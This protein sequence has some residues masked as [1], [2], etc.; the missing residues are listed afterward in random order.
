MHNPINIY[1][2]TDKRFVMIQG[3]VRAVTD[4]H[5]YNSVS[6]LADSDERGPSAPLISVMCFDNKY[7]I[8]FKALT[9]DTK[10]RFLTV[11]AEERVND[12][13]KS[14]KALAVSL[15]PTEFVEKTHPIDDDEVQN[16]CEFDLDF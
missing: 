12:G 13:R 15:A 16:D 14:Y 7:G 8:N 3:Y 1:T 4:Q 2:G 10:G 5:Y 6:F 9:N 11:F